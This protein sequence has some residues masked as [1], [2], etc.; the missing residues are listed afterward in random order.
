MRK[1]QRKSV[2]SAQS[3]VHKIKQ[4]MIKINF[5]GG[6][7]SPTSL[8]SILEIAQKTAIETVS[9][10][11]RQ[12]LLMSVHKREKILFE[13][14]MSDIN[15]EFETESDQFPNILSSYSTAEIFASTTN[16]GR[17]GNTLGQTWLTEGVYLDILNLFDYKPKLKINICDSGQSHAPFFTGHLNFISSDVPHFWFLFVRY[18]KTNRIERFQMLVYGQDLAILAQKIEVALLNISPFPDDFLE[19]ISLYTEGVIFRQI[20]NDLTIPRFVMPYFEGVNTDKTGK[21][22]L[23]I[24]RR[25]EQFPVNFLIELCQLCEQTRV[26]NIGITAWKS[27]IIKGIDPKNRFLF[28]KLLGKHGINVRHGHIELNWQTEDDS[29]KGF[30]LKRYLVE[31]FDAMDVRTFGL[32]F[33]IKTRHKSEVFGSVII[34]RHGFFKIGDFDF[35]GLFGVYDIFYAEDF[36]PHTRRRRT[37][38]LSVPRWR[39]ANELLNLSK[40][41]FQQL[42]GEKK[43]LKITVKKTPKTLDNTTISPETHQCSCCLTIYDARF[44]ALEVGITE[45]VAF[46]DLPESFVCPTCDSPKSMF[47]IVTHFEE[48]I[49]AT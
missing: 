29:P 3:V 21:M 34:R 33:A 32:V 47:K 19:K 4:I 18:P 7:T 37:H 43:A 1:N 13:R 24:Y 41:Y 27:L 38:Q 9:F 12:Q 45:G 35:W 40:K 11:A 31:Q 46:S 25:N 14:K 22:W 10:G 15:V 6:I 48:D 44:G 23:G 20:D 42:T 28:E 36:N 39:L 49:V 5:N 17:N 2:K 16:E 26:G 8:L 30:R